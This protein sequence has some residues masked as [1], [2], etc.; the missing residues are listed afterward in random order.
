MYSSIDV[1]TVTGGVKDMEGYLSGFV[2]PVHSQRFMEASLHIF[3]HI[4][5]TL[6][7]DH[8]YKVL[9]G[10]QVRTEIQ[11]DKS[12]VGLRTKV[13]VPYETHSHIQIRVLILH[14]VYNFF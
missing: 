9:H 14:I 11:E 7:T 3:W 12:L 6:S 1:V 13:S 2:T 8:T 4:T 10:V 5:P